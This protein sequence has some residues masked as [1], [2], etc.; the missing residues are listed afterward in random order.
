MGVMVHKR[1]LADQIAFPGLVEHYMSRIW[2][3]DGEVNAVV[4]SGACFV[5]VAMFPD[6]QT[7]PRP[8]EGLPFLVKDNVDVEAF[9]TVCGG[10]EFLENRP[11][12]KDS[13]HVSLLRQL[14]AIPIGKTNVPYLALDVQT[15]NDVYGP[16][17]NPYN[18]QLSAGG[19]SGGS[20]AAVAAGMAAF[21]LGNDWN[22]SLRIP[23]TIETG[24]V[25]SI[26][27]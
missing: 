22:G 13:K 17:C 19:S 4:E 11:S 27:L 9:H 25:N 24:V 21:A 5:D 16:T 8:L 2:E 18:P 20:A 15:F 6:N 3:L 7:R 1:H 23:D 26:H 10:R 12:S 14:G